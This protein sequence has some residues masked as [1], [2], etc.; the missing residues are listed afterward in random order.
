MI[1]KNLER[2]IKTET[3]LTRTMTLRSSK[4]MLKNKMILRIIKN[5]LIRQIRPMHRVKLIKMTLSLWMLMN[6]TKMTTMMTRKTMTISWSLR[7]TMQPKNQVMKTRNK[8]Q[9]MSILK[10]VMT[11]QLSKRL[12]LLK[13][14][15]YSSR[16][17][18]KRT[19]LQII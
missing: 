15:L 6:K 17:L 9:M 1:N 19:Q 5:R 8:S 18:S 12:K 13:R 10:M 11:K 4:M 14:P 7:M 16:M 2:L 3:R